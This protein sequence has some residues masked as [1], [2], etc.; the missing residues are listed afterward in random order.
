[1]KTWHY[2]GEYWYE[3][4]KT[5][6]ARIKEWVWWQP[7]KRDT[8][9]SLFGHRITFQHFG[10]QIETPWRERFCLNRER[11]REGK[12]RWYAYLSVDCTPSGATTWLFNPPGEV[13]EM[14]KNEEAPDPERASHG[15][16]DCRAYPPRPRTRN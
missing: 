2:N 16:F 9:I 6:L 8:P 5:L 10:V 7:F 12:W 15:N 14:A 4:N 3:K 11:T 1:M 13:A